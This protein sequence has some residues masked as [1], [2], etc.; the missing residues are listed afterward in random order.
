M[1]T[2]IAPPANLGDWKKGEV[3]VLTKQHGLTLTETRWC[4]PTGKEDI[5]TCCRKAPG[6]T[7]CPIA[8]NG[9]LVIVLQF[10]QGCERAVLEFPAG[11]MMEGFTADNERKAL[12]ELQAETG[13]TAD[14]LERLNA[15][16]TWPAPRKFATQETLFV[17]TGAR[18]VGSQKL[19]TGEHAIGVFEVTP[20]EFRAM[21]ETGEIFS[22]FTLLA[23]SLALEKGY[24]KL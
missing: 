13:Y 11:M 21:R 14:K 7:I 17:A 2:I 9:D 15:S 1:K 19:D 6:V 8:V 22:T 23:F 10:K 16:S 4:D 18:H 24:V 20:E 3:K 5:Y 12:A